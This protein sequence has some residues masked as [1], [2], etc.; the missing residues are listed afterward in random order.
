MTD[1]RDDSPNP[2]AQLV[3]RA[4][5]AST[6]FIRGDMARW[7]AL[8]SPIADDFTLMQPFG[9]DTSRGFD[10]T[11]ARLE[12][13][14]RLF[15]GGEASLEVQETY[16]SDDLVVLVMIERQRGEVGGLPV[17]DWSLRVTQ[18]YRRHG[19]VWQ[20]VHRHADPLVRDMSLEQTAALARGN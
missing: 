12:R 13:F 11:P 8:V 18:V 14:A 16:A 17:Q 7:Y 9:G 5:A 20:L 1:E 6:A 2:L 10:G 15:T 3:R 19:D 4:D